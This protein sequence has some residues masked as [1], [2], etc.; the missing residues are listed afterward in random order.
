[1]G[2]DYHQ[3]NHRV[4][5]CV[6]AL[7]SDNTPSQQSSIHHNSSK[8]PQYLAIVRDHLKVITIPHG[9]TSTADGL[10]LTRTHYTQSS[11][12]IYSRHLK[13]EGRRSERER[14]RERGLPY[15]RAKIHFLKH[16]SQQA[17]FFV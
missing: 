12:A 7:A 17:V 1:M 2:H 11:P 16:Q 3:S 6:P 9:C 8:F 4:R 14:E 5:P 13:G 15:P 10:E